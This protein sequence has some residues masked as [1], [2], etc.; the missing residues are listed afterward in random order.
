MKATHRSNFGF[1][2]QRF[3]K[4]PAG[5][6][7]HQRPSLKA[8]FL[9]LFL[10]LFF[11][12]NGA[13]SEVLTVRNSMPGVL[14]VYSS[15]ANDWFFLPG[16]SSLQIPIRPENYDAEWDW[17]YTA[18]CNDNAVDT[19][20]IFGQYGKGYDIVGIVGQNGAYDVVSYTE[21]SRTT[22][23]SFLV[24]MSYGLCAAGVLLL[25]SLVKRGLNPTLERA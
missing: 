25:I 20:G 22:G 24:G 17:F 16:Y 13:L 12:C 10:G 21:G 18:C 15:T 9:V 4:N 1:P 2:R 19:Y 14:K 23:W 7:T 11:M 5:E 6:I 3:D 8:V